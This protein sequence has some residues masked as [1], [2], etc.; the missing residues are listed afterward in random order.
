MNYQ[1]KNNNVFAHRDINKLNKL[2]RFQLIY[3]REEQKRN[4]KNCPWNTQN[5]RNWLKKRIKSK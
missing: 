1:Q 4:L 5:R 3:R 2:I